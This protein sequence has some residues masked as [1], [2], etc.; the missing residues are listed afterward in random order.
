MVLET[1]NR[2]KQSSFEIS[3]KGVFTGTGP[4]SIGTCNNINIKTAISDPN[5]NI[6]YCPT[7]ID[8]EIY[9]MRKECLKNLTSDEKD[10]IIIKM[11][12]QIKLLEEKLHTKFPISP[13]VS[14]N[15]KKKK[16]VTLDSNLNNNN[17]TYQNKITK[18]KITNSSLK[19][20]LN[21]NFFINNNFNYFPN[22]NT[23]K[24]LLIDNTTNLTH[25]NSDKYLSCSIN[26]N[27]NTNITNSNRKSYTR[28][29]LSMKK[30]ASLNTI[31]TSSLTKKLYEDSNKINKN[32]VI[33]NN[34]KDNDKLQNNNLNVSEEETLVPVD[35]NLDFGNSNNKIHVKSISKIAKLD[36]NKKELK[37]SYDN[38]KIRNYN[39]SNL[40]N[41]CENFEDIILKLYTIKEKCSTV[42][43]TY[44]KLCN[45]PQK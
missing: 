15:I 37:S 42:L 16:E 39:K 21:N 35:L 24:N 34:I 26:S 13:N 28:D 10:E 7:E 6:Q 19:K 9:N 25:N 23:S 32:N 30:I 5:I 27:T 45:F 4:E 17:K 1:E 8:Q 44:S 33:N 18:R 41:L 20:N 36:N 14:S 11:S 38:L 22:F 31:S 40:S 12:K 3:N 29:L 2:S 43:D